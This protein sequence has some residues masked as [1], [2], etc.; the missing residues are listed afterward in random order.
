MR[1][2]QS[3]LTG[4]KQGPVTLVG[5]TAP[6][7]ALVGH[8][9]GI[10]SLTRSRQRLHGQH[11]GYR[12]A[13]GNKRKRKRKKKADEKR[14][15][16]TKFRKFTKNLQKLSMSGMANIHIS[17]FQSKLIGRMILTNRQKVYD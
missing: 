4:H 14:E 3:S 16:D 2:C 15:K 10:T 11:R 5:I 1:G 12:L 7:H 17:D 9:E 6:A 8:S 13:K